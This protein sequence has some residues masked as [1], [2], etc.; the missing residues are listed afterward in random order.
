MLQLEEKSVKKIVFEVEINEDINLA[1]VIKDLGEIPCWS[2]FDFKVGF[3]IVNNINDD[4]IDKVIKIIKENF[5]VIW[6]YIKN[7]ESLQE[8]AETYKKEKIESPKVNKEEEALLEIIGPALDK[9]DKNKPISEQ[10]D[11][12]MREIKMISHAD[13]IKD[14][15]K[16]VCNIKKISYE[17]VVIKLRELNPTMSIYDIRDDLKQQFKYWLSQHPELAK[18]SSR[19]NLMHLLKLFAKRFQ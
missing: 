17:F 12:F 3:I 18:K 19:I 16:N 9:L 4:I 5:K 8:Q 11:N 2:S 10:V 7:T 6:M 13:L 15:L 1:K 14:A